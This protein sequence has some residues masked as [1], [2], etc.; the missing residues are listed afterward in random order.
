MFVRLNG[1]KIPVTCGRWNPL[2]A[3]SIHSP[4][5]QGVIDLVASSGVAQAA[6][7]L[8]VSQDTL[9]R[10]LERAKREVCK[11]K[12]ISSK[13]LVI[14]DLLDD[15]GHTPEKVAEIF[16][17][18]IRE[19]RRRYWRGRSRL[20]VPRHD[21]LIAKQLPELCK[22]DFLAFELHVV[23]NYS[24]GR[25]ARLLGLNRGHMVRRIQKVRDLLREHC[26]ADTPPR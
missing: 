15:L 2:K 9:M 4:K 1:E 23:L 5:H 20:Q 16:N 26:Q 14:L 25:T 13:D 24:I 22:R 10:R 21:D 7:E 19:V 3:V 18:P 11:E 12:L 6:K 8:G 17:I